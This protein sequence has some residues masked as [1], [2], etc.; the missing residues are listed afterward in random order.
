MTKI[1]DKITRIFLG[2]FI[3]KGIG[4]ATTIYL[5]RVLGTEAFGIITIALSYIGYCTWASDLG[6]ST[7]G[8]REIAKPEKNRT[9]SSKE[10]FIAKFFL[11]ILV[12]AIGLGIIELLNLSGD[13]KLVFQFYTLAIIPIA[14]I[15]EWHYNGLQRYG[16]VA[17]SRIL[18]YSV[19]L[20]LAVIFVN[21]ASDLERVPLFFVAGL[22]ASA[23][24]LGLINLKDPIYKLPASNFKAF[25]KLYLNGFQVGTGTFFTSMMQYLPPIIIG[26]F[27]TS[28]DAGLYGAAIRMILAAMIL[29][30]I[31]VQ[32]LL[33]N[34]SSQWATNK[35]LAIKNVQFTSTWLIVIGASVS[36]GIAV[37]SPFIIDLFYGPEY[38]E[39]T[40][41]LSILS[42]FLFLT[43]LNSL[44][45]FG[46][47][48]IGKDQ[49]FLK[50]TLLAG[51]V[52]FILYVGAGFS[53]NLTVIVAM[54]S[55]AELIF[56]AASLYYFRKHVS[57]SILAPTI[58]S[59]SVGI[60]LYHLSTLFSIY[61]LIEGIIAAIVII[62]I[63]WI[64]RVL[65]INHFN[66]F[67]SKILK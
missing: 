58:F 38:A 67:K 14:L 51:A 41:L 44:S 66:W 33:P 29:D 60:G 20:I 19:Y 35:E 54:I 21:S 5:A 30:R 50:S 12:S 27:L 53:R 37:S 63:L 26:W 10:I 16:T 34:L 49:E 42:I 7:I 65:D 40:P 62:P 43:F 57:I 17:L 52:A 36:V 25:K 59:I 64:V 24:F 13:E 15:L 61:P 55:V 32:L 11:A 39:S 46:L 28:S 2:D 31:F 45:A 18:T 6:L 1:R 23:I 56:V 48:A 22:I 8:S 9:Y 47:V 3:G 4:F